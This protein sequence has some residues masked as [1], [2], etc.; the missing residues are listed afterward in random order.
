M[1]SRSIKLEAAGET[2]VYNDENVSCIHDGSLDRVEAAYIRNGVLYANEDHFVYKSVDDGQTMMSLGCFRKINPSPKNRIKDVV[3]RSRCVRKFRRNI[4]PRNVIVLESGTILV[5]YDHI[6]RSEDGGKTFDTVL[7]IAGDYNGP[8]VHGIAVDSKDNVFFGE[9]NSSKEPHETKILKGTE[10][11]KKW[12]VCH[13]FAPGEIRHVHSITYDRYRDVLWICTGDEDEESRL[14][15]ADAEFENVEQVGYGDQDWRI[16][17]LMIEEDYIYWC[18]DNDVNGS[19]ICRM[20]VRDNNREI[21]K[22][23]G[24]PCYHSTVLLD[25]TKVFSTT[26]EHDSEYTKLHGPSPESEVWISKDGLE[27]HRILVFTS[28]ISPTP[29]GWTRGQVIFPAG[30]G[31]SKYLY[32]TPV[33]TLEGSLEIHRYRI[34]W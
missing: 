8:F 31:S 26:Y 29:F 2:V 16:V 3:A 27:W 24:N 21:I 20:D 28:E 14:L 5:F 1:S 13:T 23:I 15:Y 11:G 17:S 7:R 30:D 6:Y 25:G 33:N 4:G 12:S 19:S 32:L 22:Y 9:Y 18:S 34:V 10:D